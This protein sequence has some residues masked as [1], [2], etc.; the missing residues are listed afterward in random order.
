MR[1]NKP[2]SGVR[3]VWALKTKS[4]TLVGNPYALG[5]RDRLIPDW[6]PT[7]RE[8]LAAQGHYDDDQLT[9]VKLLLVWKS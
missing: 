3:A 8:A 1:N 9:P 5:K 2:A 6:W 7:R 4:G